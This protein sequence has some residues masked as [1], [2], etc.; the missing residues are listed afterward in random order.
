MKTSH[1]GL[2]GTILA[3]SG[4]DAAGRALTAS[5]ARFRSLIANATDIISILASDGAFQYVS[6]SIERILGYGRDDLVG[7]NAF[8]FV[9]PD[10]LDA[11]RSAFE[12]A[13]NDPAF[14]P[15]AEFRFR[16]RDGSWRWLESMGTN[17]LDDADVGGFVVNSRDVTARIEAEAALARERDLL[18]TLMDQLPDAVYVKDT[19]SRFLRLNPAT[20]QTLGIV[21]P[22][23]AVGKTDFDF[24]PETLAR[25]YFTDE[26]EVIA[27]GK[28]LLNR[29]EPQSEDEL[30]AFWWLT[31][32]VPLRDATGSIIGIVGSGRNITERLR[33]EEALRES[34]AR[35]RALLTALPDIVFRLDRAGTYLDYKADRLTDLAAPPESLLGRTVGEVLPI[36]VAGPVGEAIGRVLDSGGTETLEYTLDIAGVRRDF[37]ARLVAAGPDEVVAVVRDITD[38]KRLECE[39]RD[40]VAS[41]QAASRA[42]SQLLDMMSHELR[43]P[44]QAV[45]GYAELLLAGPKGSL[46]AEQ[47]EDV[48]CIHQGATRLVGFVKQMLDLSRL[49]AGQMGLKSEPVDLPQIVDEVRQNVA[50]QAAE[51]SLRLHVDLPQDLPPVLGDA[52]GIHQIL[53]N[54]VGNAV[55]FTD[56]GAVRISARVVADRVEIEVNDTGIGIAADALP[57]IFEEFHQADSGTTRRYDGAGLGLAIA[58]R[59]AEQQ[60]GEIRVTSQFGVG[61]IFTLQLSIALSPVAAS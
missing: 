32:T 37:E 22:A 9:H 36:A 42:T 24:F 11:T 28:P 26:Q 5:E 25:Q 33:T 13:V 35:H 58:R 48:R 54:L 56:R 49:E 21:D 59:L 41:A 60:A 15:K 17:L 6:P 23:D 3:A 53:L 61:S 34:E 45:M 12:Q 31:S 10:D 46:T 39:L 50:P 1:R 2:R 20:A 16:H 55:K 30:A 51:K 18:R 14:V 8:S 4:D 19:S 40:A 38:R 7:R 44:M 52:M 43:T 47:S 27:T 57:H 29:L